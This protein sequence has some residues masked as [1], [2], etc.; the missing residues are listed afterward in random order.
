MTV[1]PRVYLDDPNLRPQ[2]IAH[3]V[4]RYEFAA[5]FVEPECPNPTLDVMCG[6]GYGADILR[7]AGAVV[8]GIDSDAEA[9]AYATEHYPE[10]LFLVM[11]VPELPAWR[12]PLIT[13]FEGIEHISREDGLRT[14]RVCSEALREGGTLVVSTPRDLNE[15][16]NPWHLSAWPLT[17]LEEAARGIFSA[18]ETY[19]QDWDTA[20]IDQ[21][22]VADNDFY[23]LVCRR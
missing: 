16:Y 1:V 18:V 13:W 3:H 20:V 19:G 11:T 17:E 6:S 7:Q 22:D 5:K 21:D 4:A 23:V 10:S 2:T 14:L 9:I 15:K 12:F 8:V